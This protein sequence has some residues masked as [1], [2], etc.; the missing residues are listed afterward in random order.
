MLKRS[1]QSY[2]HI[3][4]SHHC[5]F[6]SFKTWPYLGNFS[7]QGCAF[8][9]CYCKLIVTCAV[10]GRVI[11]PHTVMISYTSFNLPSPTNILCTTFPLHI[12]IGAILNPSFIP[13]LVCPN[14]LLRVFW[15]SGLVVLKQCSIR[16]HAEIDVY[17]HAELT[18]CWG[19]FVGLEL[20]L[21]VK[22]Q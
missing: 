16:N 18:P 14:W 15:A 5:E 19:G 12:S 17:I 2:E 1:S 22:P 11:A 21:V 20:A 8:S 3:L 9:Q 6:S 7:F 10:C 13:P 4:Q